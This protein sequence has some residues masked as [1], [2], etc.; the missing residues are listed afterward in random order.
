MNPELSPARERQ[1]EAQ[2]ERFAE[3][4]SWL[5]LEPLY[6]CK[7]G[8]KGLHGMPRADALR[9]VLNWAAMR[10]SGDPSSSPFRNLGVRVIRPKTA[11]AEILERAREDAATQPRTGALT[12]EQIEQLSGVFRDYV[13]EGVRDPALEV[14]LA[15]AAPAHGRRARAWLL[16]AAALLWCFYLTVR[17]QAEPSECRPPPEAC[18]QGGP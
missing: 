10:A 12:A 4:C 11:L 3:F 1:V 18:L 17:M 13:L 9:R 5:Q 8:T 7:A 15:P 14:V 2:V 6:K 16:W